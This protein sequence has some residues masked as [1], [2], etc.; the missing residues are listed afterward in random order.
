MGCT[1][2]F[3]FWCGL[4][5]IVVSPFRRL[6]TQNFYDVAVVLVLFLELC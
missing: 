1:C 2:V 5:Q 6:R 3:L 4:V